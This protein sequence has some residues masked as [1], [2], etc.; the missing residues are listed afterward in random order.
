MDYS[1]HVW[2]QCVYGDKPEEPTGGEEP[3]EPTGG[4]EPEEPT[5]GEE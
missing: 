1:V 5:G 2:G 4:E 3:E